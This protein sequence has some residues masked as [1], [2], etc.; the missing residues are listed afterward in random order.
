MERFSRRVRLAA[1]AE[2]VFAWHESPGA[3]EAL[4]P[5]WERVRVLRRVGT[6]RDG[7][8]TWLRVA[9]AGPVGVT[10]VARH[11]GFEPGR[12]FRDVSE[13]GPFAT[14]RHTHTVEPDGGAACVLEDDIEWRLRGGPLVHAAGAPVV[15]R[16]LA[17][18]FDHRHRVMRELFGAG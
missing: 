16:R 3:F 1:P 9:V 10:W 6:I 14:W 13:G 12:R 11:E 8:R 15:R 18:L 2:R 5:P 17:R 4:T 7:D